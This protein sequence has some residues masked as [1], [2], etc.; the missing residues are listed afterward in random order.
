MAFRK[1]PPNLPVRNNARNGGYRVSVIALLVVSVVAPLLILATR[2]SS[3]RSAGVYSFCL[4]RWPHL[5]LVVLLEVVKS[6][7]L[8]CQ[9][10]LSATIIFNSA[11][12]WKG[13]SWLVEEVGGMSQNIWPYPDII[14]LTCNRVLRG[15]SC[16]DSQL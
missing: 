8:N 1:T 5:R 7:H 6:T 16:L 3:F 10:S 12:S 15:R 11:A 4:E 13:P 9:Q 14:I 2:T